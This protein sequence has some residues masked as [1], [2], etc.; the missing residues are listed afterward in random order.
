MMVN[1]RDDGSKLNGVDMSN[2]PDQTDRN[3]YM[4]KTHYPIRYR[5]YNQLRRPPDHHG[6]TENNTEHKNTQSETGSTTN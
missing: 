3:S 4:D 6:H 2:P 5:Q 1:G